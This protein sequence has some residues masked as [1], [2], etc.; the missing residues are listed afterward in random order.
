MFHPKNTILSSKTIKIRNIFPTG[1]KE[2]RHFPEKLGFFLL[3]KLIFYFIEKGVG[4]IFVCFFLLRNNVMSTVIVVIGIA[5]YVG[6]SGMEGVGD[7]S[8]FSGG[9]MIGE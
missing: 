5:I 3:S 9:A 7:G 1:E 2:K 6:N 4:V 8:S